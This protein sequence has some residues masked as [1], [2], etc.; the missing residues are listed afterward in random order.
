MDRVQ[1]VL[2]QQTQAHAG[3]NIIAVCHGG[4][5]RAA[6]ALALRLDPEVALG[7]SVENLSRSRVD[8]LPGPELGGDWRCVYLNARA[9]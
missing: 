3:R 9:K 6:L 1:G 8:H 5:I 7:L 4:V 2:E